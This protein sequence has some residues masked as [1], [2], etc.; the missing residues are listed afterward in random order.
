MRF[1]VLLLFLAAGAA[2]LTKP[3]EADAEGALRE[4]V[5]SAVARQELGA[6]RNTGENLA[7]AACKLRPNDCYEL[8]RAGL[9]VVFEDRTL[10]LKVDVAGFERQA[11]CYGVFL[12]F[13]CPGGFSPG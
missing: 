3:S 8:L 7:L 2:Y 11:S 6:G 12:R 1:L 10:Y 13:F 5:M 9:D 4:R